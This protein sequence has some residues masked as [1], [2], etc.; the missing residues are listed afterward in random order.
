MIYFFEVAP[1]SVGASDGVP[2][3]EPQRELPAVVQRLVK[4][5]KPI[6]R[7]PTLAIH[8]SRENGTAQGFK[9][10]LQSQMPPVL[11][12][13]ARIL[14]PAGGVG[15]QGPVAAAAVLPTTAAHSWARVL[16]SANGTSS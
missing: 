3:L 15:M 7:I 14:P 4:I 16:E 13:G 11:A 1:V 8:L 9:F 10:N 12:Q 5:D 2:H 6:L